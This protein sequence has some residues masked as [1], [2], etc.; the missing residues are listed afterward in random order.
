MCGPPCASS[1]SSLPQLQLSRLLQSLPR[2]LALLG[3]AADDIYSFIL[4][5]IGWISSWGPVGLAFLILRF[6]G[7]SAVNGLPNLHPHKILYRT[8]EGVL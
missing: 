3:L 6:P 2:F 4:I 7:S 1:C 8:P 5:G